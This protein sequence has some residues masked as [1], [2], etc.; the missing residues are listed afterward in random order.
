MMHEKHLEN[1]IGGSDEEDCQKQVSSLDSALEVGIV[2][3]SMMARYTRRESDVG[4]A[5]MNQGLKSRRRKAI[6]EESVAL[7]MY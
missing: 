7:D 1:V 4:Q 3:S 5:G 2:I 6:E